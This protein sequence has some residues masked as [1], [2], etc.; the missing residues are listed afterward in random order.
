MLRG[1]RDFDTVGH[2]ADFVRQMVARR[3]R[4]VQGKLE[5][6]IACLEVWPETST[7]PRSAFS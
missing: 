3:N 5:Q 6:E 7:P 1:S 2:Y 4:L